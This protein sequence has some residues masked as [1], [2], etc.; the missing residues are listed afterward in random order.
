MDI[1]QTALHTSKLVSNT[2]QK[3]I[4]E[5]TDGHILNWNKPKPDIDRKLYNLLLINFDGLTDYD[6][7]N[8][9][10]WYYI[11]IREIE[12]EL[13]ALSG[14]TTNLTI[15]IS[16]IN[17]ELSRSLLKDYHIQKNIQK[18]A[19]R[20]DGK[21]L[22]SCSVI[23]VL[24]NFAMA[25]TSEEGRV[26]EFNF[27]K[28]VLAKNIFDCGYN[29]LV[30]KSF[31]DSTNLKDKLL[32]AYSFAILVCGVNESRFAIQRMYDKY[33]DGLTALKSVFLNLEAYLNDADIT[34][35]FTPGNSY[36]RMVKKILS[37]KKGKVRDTEKNYWVS[38]IEGS[39]L[40]TALS[41]S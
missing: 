6:R 32:L 39:D 7:K 29:A 23:V 9:T 26:N 14:H 16:S 33:A 5:I 3:W 41:A 34:E 22:D 20:E 12:R 35:L 27:L 1:M 40:V 15:Q 30:E 38:C 11:S 2:G 21:L 8:A 17:N 13:Q 36:E 4:D 37:I 28:F 10:D 31:A 24:H 19:F 25:L 18:P